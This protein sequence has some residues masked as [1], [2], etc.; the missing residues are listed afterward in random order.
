MDVFGPCRR[1]LKVLFV[2][3]RFSAGS[4]WANSN[5]SRLRCHF[6]SCEDV[7]ATTLCVWIVLYF[8]SLSFFE[9]S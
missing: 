6:L 3:F 4:Q 7:V 9:P 2:R 5:R 1:T 8:I